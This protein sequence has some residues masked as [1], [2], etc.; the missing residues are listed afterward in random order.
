M[1]ESFKNG[2]R[3]I[4][5]NFKDWW[6]G[7][8][9]KIFIGEVTDKITGLV[10]KYNIDVTEINKIKAKQEELYWNEVDKMLANLKSKFHQK[11]ETSGI[12]KNFEIR[13]LEIMIN[14]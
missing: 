8:F 1:K 4:E 3:I 2:K 9:D 5:N 12:R 7:L 11:Y 6:N 14:Y 13:K 10:T